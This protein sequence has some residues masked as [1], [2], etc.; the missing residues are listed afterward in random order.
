VLSFAGLLAIAFIDKLTVAMAMPD[1]EYIVLKFLVAG[2]LYTLIVIEALVIKPDI[3]GLNRGDIVMAF[4]KL[5]GKL[6]H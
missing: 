6:S 5:R 1:H 4:A 3:F 2:V